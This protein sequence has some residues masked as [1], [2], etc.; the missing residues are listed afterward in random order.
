MRH[1]A[2]AEAVAEDAALAAGGLADQG[3]GRV[4]RLD[5]ARGVELH[6]LGVAQPA[7][8]LD[9]EPERVAGVLVAARGGATPDAGVAA[10]REDDRVGVD[11]VAGAVVE[12]EAVGAEDGTVVVT[13]SRVT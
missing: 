9:G 12:V 3:A 13:R 10:G 7:A 4:L 5:D 2:L 11:E 1:E 8:G 6:Q